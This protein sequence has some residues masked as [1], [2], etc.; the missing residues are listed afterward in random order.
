MKNVL[1]AIFAILFWVSPYAGFAVQADIAS[2]SAP[3]A[4]SQALGWTW[5]G[6]VDYPNQLIANGAG[7]AGGP[8]SFG[9]LTFQGASVDVY[10]VKGPTVT[11]DQRAH[12]TGKVKITLDGQEK[13]T[14]LLSDRDTNFGVKVYSASSLSDGIHVLQVEPVGGW[15]IVDHVDVHAKPAPASAE[16]R[17]SVNGA[18]SDEFDETAATGWK[19][20][21]GDWILYRG[22][23]CIAAGPGYKS[24]A[25]DTSFSDLIYDADVSVGAGGN[26]GVVF[27]VTNPD[28]GLDA[29]NGYYA[30][31]DVV[32]QAVV[33]GK[34]NGGYQPLAGKDYPVQPNFEYHMRVIA[35]GDRLSVDI[36]GQ[37]VLEAVDGSYQSGAIG[38]RTAGAPAAFDNI[39]VTPI[40]N[41]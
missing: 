27:R 12:R 35:R 18:F 31:L 34:S 6:M 24:L 8:G 14:V 9:A 36:N 37:R 22:K 33:L 4:S 41:P 7:H 26:I 15:A 2:P 29:Y 39:K 23:Y 25:V 16:A 40:S 32:H 28:L 38:V 17:A 3:A 20:Y 19:T 11:V 10:C 1:F 21:G 30:G 13:D 5:S